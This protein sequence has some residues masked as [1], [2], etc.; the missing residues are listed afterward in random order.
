[1]N[2]DTLKNKVFE[3]IEPSKAIVKLAIPATL[4]LLAKAAYNIVDTA[5]IGMLNS[6]IALAAVGVTL[7][8]LLIMVSIEN[9][10]ASGAAVL[11]GRHLGAKNNSEANRVVSTITGISVGIGLLLCILGIIFM[12]PLLKMFGASKVVLP[13]AKDY[14]FWM[15][16]AALV[17]LPA[18]SLNYAA[19]AESSVKIS[20]FA[21]IT[22]AVSNIILDPIFMFSW[23]LNMGVEGASLATTFSQIITFIILVWFYITKRSIIKVH[24]KFFKPDTTLLKSVIRIGI[25][26]AITQICLAAA[27]SLTNIA[28]SFLKNS[29]LIIAAYGIVQRLILIGSYIIMGFMEG[30]QPIAA[31]NFGAKNKKYFYDS[32]HFA[33]KGSIILSILIEII[34]IIFSQF[35][36]KIFNQN[37]SVIH[38][39]AC[40]LI[41]QVILY[42]AFGICYMMTLTF[43][44]INS[45]KQGL[46][47]STIRQGIFY[48]PFIIILPKYL[49]IKGIYL[50]QPLAD[51][52][53]GIICFYLIP[54]MKKIAL[55]N[56]ENN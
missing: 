14:A 30:Y 35:L 5:Y 4:G 9:I 51:I 38:Y 22:G 29:D 48:I 11:A 25:P 1:M 44:T 55:L 43:Q 45:S 47:L 10:F 54:K 12:D 13:L 18:Q 3:N 20:S 46:F 42:P 28:A 39:G 21:I 52:F 31:Y 26:S 49:D 17:N 6:E 50:S 40:L 56:M 32:V 8:L 19:R 37:P 36:I 16:I 23:G 41:S 34:Y 7:P 27:T 15:F 33:V 53:T 24:Y 2:T